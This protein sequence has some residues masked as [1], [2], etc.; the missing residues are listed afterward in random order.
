MASLYLSAMD[1]IYAIDP[2]VIFF[3]EGTGQ[4]GL[5]CA[6]GD[7][8]ATN[9]SI[10]SEYGLS[11]PRPFFDGLLTKAYVN[12]AGSSSTVLSALLK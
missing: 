4:G 11:D 9:P 10:I 2:N 3:V 12:Q 8:F 7:G 5:G 1:A 6:W